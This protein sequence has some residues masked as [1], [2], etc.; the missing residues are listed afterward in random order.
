MHWFICI[1]LKCKVKY[2]LLDNFFWSKTDLHKSLII[3]KQKPIFNNSCETQEVFKYFGL[4]ANQVNLL[5]YK[6]FIE[7]I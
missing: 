2:V 1:L 6:N 5:I 7:S 4:H 3:K